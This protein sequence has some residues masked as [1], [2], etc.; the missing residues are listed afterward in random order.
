MRVSKFTEGY[1]LA[2]AG[3]RV[4]EDTEWNEQQVAATRQG[5]M[6]ILAYCEEILKERTDS[7][8]CPMSMLDSLK[9]SSGTLASPTLLIETLF[10]EEVPPACTAVCRISCTL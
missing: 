4:L 1:E 5:I 3:I 10:H 2:E 7:V 8:S 6:K 9:S